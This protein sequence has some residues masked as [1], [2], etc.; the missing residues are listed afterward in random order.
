MEKKNPRPFLVRLTRPRYQY[1]SPTV[2]RVFFVRLHQVPFSSGWNVRLS[3]WLEARPYFWF[4]LIRQ[5]CRSVTEEEKADGDSKGE[6]RFP[7]LL[8]AKLHLV[9]EFL[10]VG[11]S[12]THEAHKMTAIE[13]FWSIVASLSTRGRSPKCIEEE[14][15]TTR[16]F[17]PFPS[18]TTPCLARIEDIYKSEVNSPA[19][20]G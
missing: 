6:V 2:Q 9:D 12:A 1:P 7:P 11:H 13:C 15:L 10:R 5:R 14:S 17:S 19:L 3:F 8:S 16:S 20:D 18:Q 4:P